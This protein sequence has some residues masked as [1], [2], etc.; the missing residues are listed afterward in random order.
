VV[1]IVA[2]AAVG[3]FALPSQAAAKTT[4]L[5]FDNQGSNGQTGCT[6]GYV[7]SRKAPTGTPCEG[8]TVAAEGNGVA[9]T[10]TYAS[11]SSAVGW[12]IDAKRPLT[13][14]V[15]IG[16]YPVVSTGASPNQTF[17]GPSGA[18]VTIQVNG[19]TVGTVSGTG[20]PAPGGTVS[21]PVK[22]KLPAKLNKK[23]VKSVTTSVTMTTGVVL[24]G[25][26]YGSNSQSKLVFPTR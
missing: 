22:L 5:Y 20:V 12:T 2:A 8:E 1:G 14:V 6:P 26:S 21:I 9:A 18:D 3:A 15:N 10:D 13:G 4:T 11:Q 25:V 7:L 23:V 17:G 24:T 16:N 19:I